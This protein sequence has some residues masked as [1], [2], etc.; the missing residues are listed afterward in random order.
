MTNIP[1]LSLPRAFAAVGEREVGLFVN[2]A[3]ADW[4]G[5]RFHEIDVE[6]WI[7]LSRINV[8]IYGR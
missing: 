6:G 2:N 4:F 5:E 3:G 1:E 7:A 8:D